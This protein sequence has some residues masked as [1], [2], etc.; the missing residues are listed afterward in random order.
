MKFVE[1]KLAGA[2]VVEIEPRSDERG[3]FARS[4]CEEELKMVYRALVNR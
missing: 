2:Y 1:T 4:F 3:F